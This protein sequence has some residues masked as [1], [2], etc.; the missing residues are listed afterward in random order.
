M[1]GL[2]G[3]VPQYLASII[4]LMENEGNNNA[5]IIPRNSQETRTFG[6]TSNE[7]NVR[8]EVDS[9]NFQYRVENN[10]RIEGQF[11]NDKV[12]NLSK[13]ALSE[14]E[15]SVLSKGLKFVMTPKEL[16]INRGFGGGT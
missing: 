6:E 5:N 10:G 12:I 3:K 16:S 2:D 8:Q 13:R 14:S 15:I 1:V 11:L 9:T 7:Q 4:F